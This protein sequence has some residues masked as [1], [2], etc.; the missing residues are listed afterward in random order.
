MRQVLNASAAVSGDGVEAVQKEQA[1]SAA[2]MSMQQPAADTS[3]Q[4]VDVMVVAPTSAFEN[5]KHL[6]TAPYDLYGPAAQ[7]FS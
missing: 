6:V 5:V 3:V 7:S 2:L 4:S 1:S